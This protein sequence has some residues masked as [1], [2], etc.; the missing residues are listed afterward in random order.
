MRSRSWLRLRCSPRSSS[1][2][3]AGR[4]VVAAS[5]PTGAA[6]QVREARPPRHLPAARPHPRP[7]HPRPGQAPPRPGEVRN[8]QL[9][10]RAGIPAD[11]VAVA[12]NVT[13]TE[14][15]VVRASSACSR[16]ARRWP[17]SSNLNFAAGQTVAEHGASSGLGR[18]GSG[19]DPQRRLAPPTSS[20]T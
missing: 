17:G 4:P 20:S 1:P 18:G 3:A 9:A 19:L 14:P 2:R 6:A 7:R 5:L 13:V 10:G 11:A 15:D 16:P 8:V 12:L